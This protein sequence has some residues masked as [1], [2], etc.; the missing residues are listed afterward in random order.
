MTWQKLIDRHGAKNIEM[1][2]NLLFN[3]KYLKILINKSVLYVIHVFIEL[4]GRDL[5]YAAI[6]YFH[7]DYNE[8]NNN[9]NNNK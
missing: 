6:K 4:F 5:C 1:A 3:A 2:Q 7:T 9:N 8:I